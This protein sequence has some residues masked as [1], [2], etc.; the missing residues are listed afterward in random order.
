MQK[1]AIE[2]SHNLKLIVQKSEQP[3]KEKYMAREGV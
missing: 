2:K 1:I 3:G